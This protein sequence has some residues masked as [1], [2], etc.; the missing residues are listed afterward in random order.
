MIVYLSCSSSLFEFDNHII[1]P[2]TSSKAIAI[3]LHIQNITEDRHFRHRLNISCPSAG[4]QSVCL[5]YHTG[6]LLQIPT[7]KCAYFPPTIPGQTR[8]LQIPII[9]TSASNVVFTTSLAYA[10]DFCHDK[11]KDSF[12]NNIGY[13][14]NR[15]VSL[16]AYASGL[17]EL[18]FQPIV[19]GGHECYLNFEILHPIRRKYLQVLKLSGI[20]ADK[21]TTKNDYDAIEKWSKRIEKGLP[22][23]NVAWNGEKASEREADD[24]FSLHTMEKNSKRL[25][26]YSLITLLY[27]CV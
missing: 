14:F 17:V 1:L 23:P 8:T 21:D 27:H 26:V 16:D 24:F 15:P 25:C 22:L 11:I 18:K 5:K 4:F 12:T 13:N 10:D 20:S 2:P 6:Q 9:N 7:V 19:T 3:T